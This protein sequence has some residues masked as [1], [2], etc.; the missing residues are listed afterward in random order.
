MRK[1]Q[2]PHPLYPLRAVQWRRCNDFAEGRDALMVHDLQLW[3]TN[4]RKNFNHSDPAQILERGAY[5]P[6][7]SRQ[8]TYDEYYAYLARGVYVNF[9]AQSIKGFRGLIMNRAKVE[10]I[11]PA[12]ADD[13]DLA[14]TP[15]IEK[16]GRMVEAVLKLSRGGWLIDRPDVMPGTSKADEEQEEIRPYIVEYKAEDIIYWRPARIGSVVKIA[17]VVLR[18][19]A[20]T[21]DGKA[22]YQYRQL[23]LDGGYQ[24]ILW[25]RKNLG[26]EY[27]PSA[28]VIPLMGNEPIPEIPFYFFDP[29]GGEPDPQKPF[30]IDLVELA[31]AHYQSSVD[32]RHGAFAVSLPTPA[33]HGYPDDFEPVLGGL[34]TLVATNPDAS[35][36]FLELTGQGLDP[37]RNIIADLEA[38]IAKLGGRTLGEEK[39]DAETAETVRI[40]S[41]GESAT[42]GDV[43][44][45]VARIA[46]QALSFMNRWMG[47]Q[48]EAVVTLSTD[49]TAQAVDASTISALE[50]AR[51]DGELAREDWIDYLKKIGVIDPERETEEIIAALEQEAN[52]K[53]D[54]EAQKLAAAVAAAKAQGGD[55]A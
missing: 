2:D 42:L 55:K 21:S 53:A 13:C 18:E 29:Y 52:E 17:E 6:P 7:L 44:V 19:P 34:S 24:V 45:S 16:I 39:K 54:G 49:Y 40:R 5:I 4:R 32:L 36:N 37:L 12:V 23:L 48:S 30:S 41:S 43:A 15:I 10:G 9:V 33:F 20:T 27:A 11:A 50:K 25:T 1:I 47:A 31:R 35:E 28:P 51:V 46:G 38:Q 26:D 3:Y 14:G 22:D 8:Q